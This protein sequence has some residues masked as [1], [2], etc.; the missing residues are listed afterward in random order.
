MLK[1]QWVRAPAIAVAANNAET[2]RA[3]T[4]RDRRTEGDDPDRIQADVHPGAMQEG[5]SQQRP[6][7]RPGVLQIEIARHPDLLEGVWI[8]IDARHQID[9]APGPDQQG[10]PARREG[11]LID[12]RV[13]C[14]IRHKADAGVNGEQKSHQG[15]DDERRV[16][17]RLAGPGRIQGFVG[18]SFVRRH[19]KL[20]LKGKE[21]LR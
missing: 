16:E 8:E 7:V 12:K 19:R 17:N 20:D 11:E 21:R 6:E 9:E 5:V 1:A 14:R 13:D 15:D 4:A 18:R 2:G 3:E 10:Q